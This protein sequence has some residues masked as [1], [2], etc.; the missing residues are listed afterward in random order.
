MGSYRKFAGIFDQREF[1]NYGID[2]SKFRIEAIENI[3]SR[4]K[5]IYADNAISDFKNNPCG[6]KM[7]NAIKSFKQFNWRKHSAVQRGQIALK[8][9]DGLIY[10]GTVKTIWYKSDKFDRVQRIHMHDFK[11]PA[12]CFTNKARTFI[13]I[14][15][16]RISERGILN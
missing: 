5:I 15:P 7:K 4:F 1:G 8:P 9:E 14:M 12:M 13:I 10:I 16:T 6:T 3:P 11:K 2:Y